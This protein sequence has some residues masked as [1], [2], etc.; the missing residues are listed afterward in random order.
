[1][2]FLWSQPV[3]D[4]IPMMDSKIVDKRYYVVFLIPVCIVQVTKLVH[5]ITGFLDFFHL[6]VFLGVETQ[7][8]GNWICF[9]SQMTGVED[10]SN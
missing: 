4:R 5:R 10:T 7:R 3:R 1:M 2:A 9:R 6:P 8:F